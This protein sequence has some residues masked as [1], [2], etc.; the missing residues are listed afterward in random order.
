MRTREIADKAAASGITP[1]EVML[2]A[3]NE[4]RLLGEMAKAA[5]YANMAAPYIH[6]R[7]SAVTSTAQVTGTMQV[8]LVD[9]FQDDEPLA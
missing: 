7:L 2:E 8:Q 1:L 5:T 3:M 9:E 6:P 4:A